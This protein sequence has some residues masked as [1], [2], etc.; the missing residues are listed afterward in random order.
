MIPSELRIGNLVSHNGDIVEVESI[1]SWTNQINFGVLYDDG[2][3][4]NELKPIIINGDWLL[5]LGF[6]LNE[7]KKQY[8]KCSGDFD[9]DFPIWLYRGGWCASPMGDDTGHISMKFIHQLQNLYFAL[10]GE[11]LKI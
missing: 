2:I 10:I 4:V 6:I 1:N 11:E 5:R 3:S 7:S 8:T 9:S